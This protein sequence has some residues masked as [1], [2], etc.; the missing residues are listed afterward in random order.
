[1][2]KY[3]VGYSYL[4]RWSQQFIMHWHEFLP[5]NTPDW[6]KR[7]IIAEKERLPDVNQVIITLWLQVEDNAGE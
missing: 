5:L 2:P 3:E 4:D 7:Q 1:M 6:R